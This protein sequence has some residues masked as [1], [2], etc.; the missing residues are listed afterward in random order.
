VQFVSSVALVLAIFAGCS[1][2]STEPPP[3]TT[4]PAQVHLVRS[5]RGDATRSV[6]LPANVL[7]YQQA[8]L[9]AKVGGYV[10][11]VNVDKGDG[12]KEGTLLADIEVPELI[13]DRAKYQ[14]ELEVAAVDYKRV[15]DGEGEIRYRQ[16][17]SCSHRYFAW[18]R[19][20]YR[21]IRRRDHPA[22]GG[23]R[24]I[25]PGG[26]VRQRGPECRLIHADGF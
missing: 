14:A 12:V 19:Q 21:A 9:Y 1:G 2:T 15:S 25:H 11:S 3:K 16:S 17:E 18:I 10:K 4:P 5:K 13:A 24:G 7:P 8:T 6:V 20:N 26:N 22:H 23:S